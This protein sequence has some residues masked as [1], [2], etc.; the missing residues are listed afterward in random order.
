VARQKG[1]LSG[2]G[3]RGKGRMAGAVTT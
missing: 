3:K 1:S 2:S